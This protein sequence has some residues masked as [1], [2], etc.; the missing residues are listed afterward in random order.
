M[1]RRVLIS[2]GILTLMLVAGCGGGE[3]RRP[4]EARGEAVQPADPTAGEDA[5]G[6][7]F[8]VGESGRVVRA[9][10]K[11]GHVLWEVDVID[12]AG[13]PAVG[14]P[15][16]RDVSVVDGEVVVVYGKHS[17]AHLDRTTGKLLSAGSD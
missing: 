1:L 13:A 12:K 4:A 3:K 5:T 10:D 11:A 15:V 7:V 9:T 16:I 14:K 2:G 8:P 6:I 17:F